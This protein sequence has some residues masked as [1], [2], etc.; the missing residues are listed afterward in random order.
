MNA[1]FEINSDE[2][3]KGALQMILATAQEKK[4]S[5]DEAVNSLLDTLAERKGLMPR[6]PSLA[7][8]PVNPS[9]PSPVQADFQPGQK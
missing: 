4:C 5:P 8:S 7:S 3:S 6:G 9:T 2:F 1:T